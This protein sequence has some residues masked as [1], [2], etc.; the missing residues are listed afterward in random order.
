MGGRGRIILSTLIGLSSAAAQAGADWLCTE[1]SSQVR[2]G[3]I[4][5]CGVALGRDENEARAKSFD[6]AKSEF[7]RVC[8]ASD[9][10]RGRLFSLEPKR[11]SCSPEPG[12]Y[13]CYRL[14]TFTIKEP[15][16]STAS[17]PDAGQAT[18]PTL[19]RLR[20]AMSKNGVL[21]ALGPAQTSETSDYVPGRSYLRYRGAPCLVENSECSV[22][23]DKDTVTDYENFKPAIA[24]DRRD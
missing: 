20:R 21:E 11:T 4:L 17:E 14:L 8:T 22:T 19:P 7:E 12:G 9:A 23:F 24:I 6:N 13:K 1:E 3:A 15:D 5:S 16:R 2:D 18:A 10:C